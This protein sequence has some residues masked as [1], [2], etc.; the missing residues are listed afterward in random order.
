METSTLSTK[1]QNKTSLKLTDDLT[2]A[3]IVVGDSRTTK[4]EKNK[5]DA[6]KPLYL[7]RI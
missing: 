3:I 5:D 4:L 1:E 7:K 2:P 6:S